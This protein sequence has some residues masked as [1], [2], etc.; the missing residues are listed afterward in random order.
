MIK[1]PNGSDPSSVLASVGDR[2]AEAG[3]ASHG[4]YL[5]MEIRRGDL[6]SEAPRAMLVDAVSH[7]SISQP[8]LS[9]LRLV[10]GSCGRPILP[11]PDSPSDGVPSASDDF[12]NC[13]WGFYQSGDSTDR[14]SREWKRFTSIAASAWTALCDSARSRLRV[15]DYIDARVQR[16]P[17][18]CWTA[19]LFAA[20]WS[21]SPPQGLKADRFVLAGTNR[22]ELEHIIRAPVHPAIGNVLAK[23]NSQSAHLA[24]LVR[25]IDERQSPGLKQL[26]TIPPRSCFAVLDPDVFLASE[27]LCKWLRARS[28][29]HRQRARR[30]SGGRR[31][32]RAR[33]QGGH[34][35]PFGPWVG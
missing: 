4:L 8:W 11:S 28:R 5:A 27:M 20:A 30:R 29:R 10:A 6:E 33:C 14:P 22:A 25:E 32:G 26:V 7:L 2:F 16:S 31:R 13:H 23:M 1:K 12:V 35:R 3:K 17:V 15:P 24:A 21:E 34:A 9:G 19:A 18:D